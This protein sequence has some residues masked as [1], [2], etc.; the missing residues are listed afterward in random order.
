MLPSSLDALLN[1]SKTISPQ[2]PFPSD[3]I[4]LFVLQTEEAEHQFCTLLNNIGTEVGIIM[5]NLIS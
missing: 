2:K 5:Q 3:G 4:T 1:L